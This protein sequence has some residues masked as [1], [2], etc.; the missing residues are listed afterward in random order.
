[1]Q[2]AVAIQPCAFQHLPRHIDLLGA[3]QGED[4]VLAAVLADQRGRQPQPPPGLKARRHLEDRGGQQVDLVVDDQAP[5]PLIEQGQVRELGVVPRPPGHDVVGRHGHGPDVLG[6]TAVLAD[7]VRLK[8]GL[9]QQLGDPL[10]GGRN[11]RGQHQR[12]G[13]DFGHAGHADDGLARPARQDDD[14]GAAPRAAARMKDPGRIRLIVP[15][16]EGGPR[17]GAAAQVDRQ[18]FA[19]AVS[20]Q[21]L[22]GK[23]DL[24]QGLL[25]ASAGNRFDAEGGRRKPLDQQRRDVLVAADLLGQRLVGR[26]EHQPGFVPIQLQPPI[27]RGILADLHGHVLRHVVLG[28]LLERLHDFGGGDPGGAGVPDRQR[29]DAVGVDVLRRLD[30]LGEAGQ[31]VPRSLIA[32]AIDLDQHGVVALHDQ[33]I[34][35]V[36]C[37]HRGVASAVGGNLPEPLA[38]QPFVGQLGVIGLKC[39]WKKRSQRVAGIDYQPLVHLVPVLLQ[40]RVHPGKRTFHRKTP[41]VV[42]PTALSTNELPRI[43]SSNG[44]ANNAASTK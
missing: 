34:L 11:V 17:G 31:A 42:A 37:G 25:D 1:M 27:A 13:L 26:P 44:P 3:D 9:V 2:V 12:R 19:L 32:G 14:A 28:K 21:V 24:H 40:V 39:M 33:W 30:Q 20:G 35:G 8:R 22:R 4:V 10:P 23:A 6:G 7:L 18:R 41:R 16:G 29:R 38:P 36:V 43:L 15:Q 5:V